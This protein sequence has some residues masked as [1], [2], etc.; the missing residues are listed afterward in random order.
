[1]REKNHWQRITNE[2]Y[3]KRML[4]ESLENSKVAI[5]LLRDLKEGNKVRAKLEP[6]GK[7]MLWRLLGS[8]KAIHAATERCFEGLDNRL[9][10]PQ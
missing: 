4:G 1:M 2:R 8:A 5:T 7:V 9:F 10:F 3:L 6:S